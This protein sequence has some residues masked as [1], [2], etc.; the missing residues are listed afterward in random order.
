[1]KDKNEKLNVVDKDVDLIEVHTP[2][3]FEQH[4]LHILTLFGVG[5]LLFTFMFQIY[6]VPISIVGRSMQPTINVYSTSGEDRKHCDLVY[7]RPSDEYDIGDIVI[8]DAS[9]YLPNDKSSIIKRVIACQGDTLTFDFGN[10]FKSDIINGQVIYQCFYTLSINGEPYVEDYLAEQNCYLTITT[11]KN[12]NLVESANYKNIQQIYNTLYSTQENQIMPGLFEVT[13]SENCAF[14]CGD[15]R[16]NSTDSRY[17][18]EIKLDDIIGKMVIHIPYG[19][20]LF[21][22]L[23]NKIFD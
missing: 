18:G 7:Y 16:N 8:V 12:G 4:F 5:F 13:I 19:T 17:F 14:V 22:G 15:N 2:N 1:M 21:V 9:D 11:D 6:F 23:W 20:N 3:F 10:I